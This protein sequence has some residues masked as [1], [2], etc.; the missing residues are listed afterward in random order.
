[1]LNPVK[2]H[3]AI[4]AFLKA[5]PNTSKPPTLNKTIRSMIRYIQPF[6]PDAA[7]TNRA[8]AKA[9]FLTGPSTYLCR[10][11]QVKV[12]RPGKI[13][14]AN[15]GPGEYKVTGVAF[16]K[17]QATKNNVV[18]VPEGY[19]NCGCCEEDVLLDFYFWKTWQISSPTTGVT[20]GWMDQTLDPRARAFVTAAFR[21]LQTVSL[22]ELYRGKRTWEEQR[23]IVLAL[24]IE[25]LKVQLEAM[26]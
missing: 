16:Q 26:L 19:F 23:A 14:G 11:H 20:E 21:N 3:K 17:L 6:M 5:L 2:G 24:M 25:R 22:D 1:M 9:C 7:T 18:V 4:A 12:K 15:Q 13:D 10:Y 8:L